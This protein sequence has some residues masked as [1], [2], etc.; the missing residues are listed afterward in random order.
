MQKQTERKRHSDAIFIVTSVFSVL[1]SFGAS[2]LIYREH[3][4]FVE[5]SYR[6]TLTRAS[7][8]I[9]AQC[10]LLKDPWE[11]K[12]LMFQNSPDYWEM[13]QI[14]SNLQESMGVSYIYILIKSDS[15]GKSINESWHFL[16]SSIYKEGTSASEILEAYTA[17]TSDK[18]LRKAWNDKIQ[19]YYEASDKWGNF[20]S[21]A[22][23]VVVDGQ[24]RCI[25]GVDYD[26][27]Y[28]RNL[29]KPGLIALMV[30][31][32]ASIVLSLLIASHVRHTVLLLER[33]V[34]ERTKEL[35]EQTSLAES[36]SE[37]KS[38]FLASMSHEIR[39]PMNA[40]MGMSELMPTDNM[41]AK[42]RQY[43]NDIKKMSKSLLQIINEILDVSKIESGKMDLL[44]VDFELSSL[45][46]S[47]CSIGLFTAGSKSLEFKYYYS[48]NLPRFLFADDTRI[49][50]I[51]T[52]LLNNAIKYTREGYVM[53]SFTREH[54]GPRDMLVIS[55]EDSG[56]GIEEKNIPKLF[57]A[58][59]QFD[60]RQNRGI[61]GTGLGLVITKELAVLMGGE[62]FVQSVY[63]RGSTFTV[64]IPIIEGETAKIL[65]PDSAPLV[66]A[67]ADTKIL[68]VDDN[69]MNCTV[70]IGFLANHHI[71][72]DVAS[73]GLEAIKKVQE[74]QYD[75]VFM[76]HMM[77]E[78]DGTVAT[79]KIRSL[80]GE[81]YKNLPII[82][83]SANA[84]GG[85][86][87][88]FL[89]SG[90]DDFIAKPIEK[91]ELNRLLLKWL[92]PQKIADKSDVFAET[93]HIQEEL[94][95]KCFAPIF[96]AL[97]DLDLLDIDAAL[98]HCG[99]RR[100]AYVTIL[101]QFCIEI[102]KDIKSIK[103]FLSKDNT[104]DYCI[105][106]HSMKS[107]L[108]N[109]G[110]INLSERAKSLE[111]ASR[112]KDMAYC[113]ARTEG[114]CKDVT[115]LKE[116]LLKLIIEN[117]PKEANQEKHLINAQMLSKILGEIRIACEKGDSDTVEHFAAELKQV[118]V[119]DESI[120]KILDEIK[121]AALS[122]DYDILIEKISQIKQESL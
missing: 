88:L 64:K 63:G 30:S 43:F 85:A 1:V 2:F 119:E 105:K 60:S 73:S 95:A 66:F 33:G 83:L 50:Q 5:L 8:M 48:E 57:S 56:I 6:G 31:L 39:T 111:D 93:A 13:Q 4:A 61:I 59:Q 19:T 49:R 37:A 114:F 46:E 77:P 65:L 72:P 90:M 107:S 69:S 34:Y 36:A 118:Q 3:V 117:E 58:F 98:A 52:N 20:M 7:K 47:V 15:E 115:N 91:K 68:V 40:I 100:K 94:D 101:R 70:A 21:T 24:T 55:V 106:V 11:V 51:V 17:F 18:F 35:A 26:I 44:P 32:V 99:G 14:L 121:D 28:V 75:I 78:M 23:P 54:V 112:R 116:T 45:F 86:K 82:A 53:L 25:I 42:Q 41:N 89:R 87:D 92:P 96:D 22:R 16:A 67:S 97:L 29:S 12:A 71:Y 108:A 113:I 81:Y 102:D 76:D 109:I 122:F 103:K 38:R 110:S 84:V 120:N 74:N 9:E 79:M 10:P 27:N 104:N 80:E 62:V